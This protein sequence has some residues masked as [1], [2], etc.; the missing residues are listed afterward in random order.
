MSSHPNIDLQLLSINF[1]FILEALLHYQIGHQGSTSTVSTLV[2]PMKWSQPT[3]LA[4]SQ[5]FTS[6]LVCSWLSEAS[7]KYLIES[8]ESWLN[9]SL[10]TRGGVTCAWFWFE[11]MVHFNIGRNSEETSNDAH[12]TDFDSEDDVLDSEEEEAFE[13]EE[14]METGD[15]EGSFPEGVPMLISPPGKKKVAQHKPKS[16]TKKKAATST[17][18]KKKISTRAKSKG[19]TSSKKKEV[20]KASAK[21]ASAKKVPAKKAPAKK[22]PA[23]KA[24]AKKVSKKVSAKRSKSPAKKATKKAAAT[25][26]RSTRIRASAR[27]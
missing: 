13:E 6:V 9:D 3:G 14:I 4:L 22:V 17:T 20:T 16:S 24:S 11:A 12:N 21:K 15:G 18:P 5:I 8:D 23:K 10:Y 2:N 27:K 1:W 25:P 7:I 26:R 19:R